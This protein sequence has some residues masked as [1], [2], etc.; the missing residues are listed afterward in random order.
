MTDKLKF[1]I[2]LSH[3]EYD[4]DGPEGNAFAIIG[5]VTSVISQLGEGIISQEEID[6]YCNEYRNKARSG[7]YENLLKVSNDYFH[8]NWYHG[9]EGDE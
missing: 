2:D 4:L 1:P 9:N 5:F 6:Q 8:V 3:R 7:D